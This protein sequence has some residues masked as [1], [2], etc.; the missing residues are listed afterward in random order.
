MLRISLVAIAL[1]GCD[2]A[3]GATASPVAPPVS[4]APLSLTDA[5]A[6]GTFDVSA[7]QALAAVNT[8]D[9]SG[10]LSRNKTAY[11]SVRFQTGLAA[12]VG[13]GVVARD[14]GAIAAGVSALRYAYSVQESDGGFPVVPPPDLAASLPPPSDGDIAS[15]HAFFLSE[16]GRMLRLLEESSTWRDD[17]S[18]A[19][20]RQVVDSLRPRIALS[21]DWLL[22]REMML[23]S[24]DAAAPNRLLFDAQALAATGRWL[25]RADALDAAR[26]FVDAALALQRGD[27]VFIEAGGHDS[28]YQAVALLR[29]LGTWLALPPGDSTRARLWEAIARG[30]EWQATRI[31]SDGAISLV[32]NTRVFPGGESFLGQ[33]KGVAWTDTVLAFW[34]VAA[35]TD[36]ALWRSLGQRV[37]AHYR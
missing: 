34:Y 6:L 20:E 27:G 36:D 14:A 1:L 33:E 17:P 15:G 11:F 32:G 37:A 19:A 26:R 24:Y 22:A 3:G 30:T 35:L 23:R 8:P 18:L 4:R 25:G 5:Q 21:L 29:G 28:S 7:L 9:A 31:G 16:V 2:G 13:Y 10:A 12:T